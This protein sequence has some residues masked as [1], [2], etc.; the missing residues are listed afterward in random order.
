MARVPLCSSDEAVRAL[1]RLGFE[2]AHVKGSHATYRHYAADGSI[3]AVTV[4]PL[5]KRELKRPLVKSII[6]RAKVTV[7]QFCACLVVT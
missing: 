6:E 4:V 2:R 3:D 7:D 5:G 1:T